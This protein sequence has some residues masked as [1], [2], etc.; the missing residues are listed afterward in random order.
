M[1]FVAHHA[2]YAIDQAVD[3]LTDNGIIVIF[4][5]HLKGKSREEVKRLCSSDLEREIIARQGAEDFYQRVTAMSADDYA[6]RLSFLTDHSPKSRIVADK[7]C[8][9]AGRK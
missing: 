7:F 1:F 3:L 5:Y 2:V 8:V 6:S 9:V 4:D